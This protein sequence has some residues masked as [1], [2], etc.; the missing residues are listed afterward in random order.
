[1]EIVRIAT[2][3]LQRQHGAVHCVASVYPVRAP[4]GR[5]APSVR[6]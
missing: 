5:A 3:E 1:V 4:T 6:M 2:Q